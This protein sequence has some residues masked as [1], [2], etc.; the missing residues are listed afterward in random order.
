MLT[1]VARRDRKCLT[2]RHQTVVI[3]KLP[4]LARESIG[5]VVCVSSAPGKATCRHWELTHR[6][7]H[8]QVTMFCVSPW[9]LGAGGGRVRTQTGRD[10]Q[11]G[12][13]ARMCPLETL[14]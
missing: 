4:Q 3:A 7:K 12:R 8:G 9:P 1:Q 14:M 2:A 6:E 13:L 10:A 5:V 11:V